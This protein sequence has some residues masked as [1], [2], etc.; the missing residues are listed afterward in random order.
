MSVAVA[1]RKWASVH[2]SQG[3]ARGEGGALTQQLGW[4]VRLMIGTQLEVVQTSVCRHATAK[5]Y[6]YPWR[7]PGPR[8]E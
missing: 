1:P 3:P 8:E 7:S 2:P 5:A 6:A 4:E